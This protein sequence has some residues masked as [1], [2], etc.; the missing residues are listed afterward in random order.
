V[1]SAQEVK[2]YSHELGIDDIRITNAEPFEQAL[3]KHR[4]QSAEGLFIDNRDWRLRNIEH[5]YNVRATFPKARS[6]IA[7]CQCYLTDENTDFTEPGRP[8][9]RIARYTW[10]NHYLDLRKKLQ[11]I[12]QFLKK[13]RSAHSFVYSNGPIAEKPI[14]QRSGIGYYGKHSII[15]NQVYGSW[16]VIGEIITDLDIEYDA[17]LTIDCGD[18]RECMDACPTK[19]IIRPYVIDRR[20]CIQELT[21]WYGIIPDAIARIWENRLYGCTTCQDVCPINKEVKPRIPQTK[22][23]FVG[24]CLPLIDIL[25]MDEVEYR[26]RFAHNQITAN[27]IN[28]LSIQRNALIALAHTK[29]KTTLSL[30]EQFSKHQDPVLSKTAKWAITYFLNNENNKKN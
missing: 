25:Q 29:D 20:L 27:W 23:G 1:I 4:D 19:A 26:Q 18:C 14:A 16:I 6:I 17:P 8:F 21:N 7:A 15:M 30:L 11:R 13:S 3:A 2:N 9:G 28:F 10:R 24:S 5:F 12:A 22:L